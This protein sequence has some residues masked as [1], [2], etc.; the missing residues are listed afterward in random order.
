ML[1]NVA[2]LKKTKIY[3]LTANS[4]CIQSKAGTFLRRK[5]GTSGRVVPVD[6]ERITEACLFYWRFNAYIIAVLP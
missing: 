3:A 6:P 4:V 1:H 2:K 5:S